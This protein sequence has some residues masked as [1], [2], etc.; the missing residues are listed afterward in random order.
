MS[1][2]PASG[3]A[4]QSTPGG[5]CAT[6]RAV[7][8]STLQNTSR[9]SE[10]RRI[11]LPSSPE[12]AGVVITYRYWRF[13]SD[14]SRMGGLVRCS[15]WCRCTCTG[16]GTCR[17]VPP[18]AVQQDPHPARRRPADTWISAV[19]VTSHRVRRTRSVTAGLF[20]PSLCP[21]RTVDDRWRRSGQWEMSRQVCPGKPSVGLL[22]SR[23]GSARHVVIAQV[24]P[25]HFAP[26]DGCSS[27]S[28][29]IART[30]LSMA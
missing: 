17:A 15:T 28:R 7:A 10:R 9:S 5:D 24:R 19:S 27:L 26:H 20:G 21:P 1:A 23:P 6:N 11:G 14:D 30:M 18:T 8:D 22:T 2:R 12:D 3:A 16:A 13:R 25:C 4:V 29:R